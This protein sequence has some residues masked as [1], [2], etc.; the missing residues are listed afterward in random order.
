MQRR[1]LPRQPRAELLLHSAAAA[2]GGIQRAQ[3]VLREVAARTQDFRGHDGERVRGGRGRRRPVR[4]RVQ[5]LLAGAEQFLGVMGLQRDV[6][7]EVAQQVGEDREG[8][9]NRG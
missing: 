8:L 9:W 5:S 1:V 7:R 3:G 6:V 4:R 2:A